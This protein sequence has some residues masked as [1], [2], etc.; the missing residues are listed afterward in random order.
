MST[1]AE[2][3]AKLRAERGGVPFQPITSPTGEPVLNAESFRCP[4]CH[5]HALQRWT[6]LLRAFETPVGAQY[7][8]ITNS[9]AAFCDKCK[10]FS[11]WVNEKMIF[12]ASSA[13]PPAAVD[14]PDNVQTD[15]KEASA[16]FGQ[17]PRSA[18]ALLRLGLQ[19]LMLHLG[20]K[21]DNINTDIGNLVK[22]GLPVEVQK[23]LDTV[24]VVGNNAVHPGQIDLNDDTRTA[25]SLFR[26]INFVIERMITQPR[27]IHG[28]YAGLPQ[29]SRDAIDKRDGK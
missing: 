22:K 14:M 17:S 7:C 8:R 20:E 24:R 3:L 9:A 26:L 28:L 11:I 29:T 18:A 25:A 13:A 23:A 27:E 5:V 12:P 6:P 10:E 2:K 19:K 21:G 15:Y 16:V 4:H 1:A